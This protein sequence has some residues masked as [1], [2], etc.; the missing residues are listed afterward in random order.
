MS[1]DTEKRFSNLAWTSGVTLMNLLL[2]I[3]V[4]LGFFLYIC[5]VK[6]NSRCKGKHNVYIIQ[7]K[8]RLFYLQ[9]AIFNIL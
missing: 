6:I 2:V 1:L 9:Y 5:G 4:G 8:R 7:T 3:I